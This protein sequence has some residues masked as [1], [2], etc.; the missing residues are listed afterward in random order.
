[1]LQTGQAIGLAACE[2]SRPEAIEI[3]DRMRSTYEWASKIAQGLQQCADRLTHGEP[4]KCD[5]PAQAPP[6]PAAPSFRTEAHVLLDRIDAT[7]DKIERAGNQIHR[8][9]GE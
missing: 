8:F 2:P 6:E 5:A 7:L 9:T 3:L 4:G 1:M